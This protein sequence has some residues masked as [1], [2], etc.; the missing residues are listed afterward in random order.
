MERD[1]PDRQTAAEGIFLLQEIEKDAQVVGVSDPGPR[2]HRI[3][4]APEK[5]PAER[6]QGIDQFPQTE[7][8]VLF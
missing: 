5:I 2:L 4:H 1:L 6:R 3:L 8:I 7:D